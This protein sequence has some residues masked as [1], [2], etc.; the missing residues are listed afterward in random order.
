M[1]INNINW[2]LL[3][4]AIAIGF[5]R[6][7][8]GYKYEG[9]FVDAHNQFGCDSKVEDIQRLVKS[10]GV[11]FTLLSARLP[12]DN[13]NPFDAHNRVLDVIST[14]PNKI[15][16][17]I[18]TKIGGRAGTANRA[19]RTLLR[20]EKEL[21]PQAHGYAEILIQHHETDDQNSTFKGLRMQP[22]S[23]EIQRSIEVV[24]RSKKPLILHIEPRDHPDMA[25]ETLSQLD[26]LLAEVSPYPVFLIHM[27][28]LTSGQVEHYLRRHK[29]LNFVL[30]TVE[31]FAQRGISRR[32]SAGETAQSGWVNIFED[33]GQS[34]RRKSFDS[35]A[36]GVTMKPEWRR[37]VESF[38]DRFVIGIESVYARPWLDFY[39]LK[40]DF[41]RYVLQKLPAEVSKKIACE[42]AVRHWNLPLQC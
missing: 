42:N 37:L 33:D 38:P 4:V 34:F 1:R 22:Y 13:E 36:F 9:K 40:V 18:S 39:I 26:K 3:L 11:D 24:M 2:L 12:C 20:A 10:S 19:Y 16:L 30:S 17:L 8:L 6:P 21:L 32:L 27:G 31:P 23:P 29:N 41:W 28:Q 7:A 14:S 25:A 35:W 15:G 5:T